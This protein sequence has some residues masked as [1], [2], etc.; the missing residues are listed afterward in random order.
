MLT[1]EWADF[2]AV[3]I[4]RDQHQ[5]T[6]LYRL[7]AAFQR[8]GR[9]FAFHFLHRDFFLDTVAAKSSAT[10]WSGAVNTNV[11]S[12]DGGGG[13]IAREYTGS[14]IRFSSHKGIYRIIR[15]GDT[16][17]YTL[18]DIYLD[19]P[20]TAA[21]VS[22]KITVF[23][24]DYA[25]AS[26]LPHRMWPDQ[27][28]RD[29]RVRDSSRMRLL[30]YDDAWLS[31]MGEPNLHSP[32][33]SSYYTLV[34]GNRVPSPKFPPKVEASGVAGTYNGIAGRYYFGCT[35]YDRQAQLMSEMGP[36]MYYDNAVTA[37]PFSLDMEYDSPSEVPEQSYDLMLWCSWVD[38]KGFDGTNI[39]RAEKI[40]SRLI[41][42]YFVGR[43]PFNAAAWSTI[44]MDRTILTNQKLY[45]Q[46][47]P[48]LVRF[49]NPPKS[50]R[51]YEMHGK[52][53]VPWYTDHDETPIVP[54]DFAELVLMAIDVDLARTAGGDYASKLALYEVTM[55][56]IRSA[57][58]IRALT[59]EADLRYTLDQPYVDRYRLDQ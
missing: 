13:D 1:R 57:D 48:T 11:I 6:L 20:L 4:G 49:Y 50:A 56:K 26:P 5:H 12:A 35:F 55:R 18:N 19:R 44:A 7:N 17:M 31:K 15:V 32:A 41:P 14:E 59:Q 52:S 33:E 34:R 47:D 25:P 27:L 28:A 16:S 10:T 45:P 21:V 23:R 8:I 36:I 58:S 24:R 54:D 22:D 46:K 37:T 2:V 30:Y 53:G 9:D 29:L 43:H 51:P 42:F 38:P 40:N 3:H 39:I